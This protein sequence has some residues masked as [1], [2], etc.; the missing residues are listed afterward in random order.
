MNQKPEIIKKTLLAQSR[1]FDIERLHLKFSNGEERH[2]KRICGRAAGSVMIVPML[3]Q[4]TVL[5]IREYSAGLHDYILGFPKGA[6]E[7][8]EDYLNTALRELK[9]EAGYGAADLEIVARL[10]ASPGYLHSVMHIVVA[11]GLYEE[12][13]EGDE[14]EPIEVIPW[15]LKNIDDLLANPEFHEARSVAALLLIERLRGGK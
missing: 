9:E 6:V 14:P 8:G 13:I 1:L 2:F 12:R 15:K 11:K 7:I 10:S 4:D 3:D 5:L